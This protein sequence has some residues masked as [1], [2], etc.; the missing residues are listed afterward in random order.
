MTVDPVTSLQL[1]DQAMGTSDLDGAVAHL[2][3]AV[4][5]FSAAGDDRAA[6][7]A[8]A[9]LGELYLYGMGN[10]VAAR[11]WFERAV[12]LVAD[13]EPCVEQGWVAIAPLGCD[14]DDPALLLDRA[15]LARRIR[16][17]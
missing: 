15:T 8:S 14:V 10:K 7:L 2:S 13:E 16:S 17:R 11:P 3:A 12:R 1:A 6:A 4:R 5:S 9:R